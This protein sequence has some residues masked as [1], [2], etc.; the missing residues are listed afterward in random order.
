M[1]AYRGWKI[2]YLGMQRWKVWPPE[3]YDGPS[4]AIIFRNGIKELIARVN[5][6]EE[7]LSGYNRA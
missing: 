6:W 4:F 7:V 2:V 3:W 5:L 1:V